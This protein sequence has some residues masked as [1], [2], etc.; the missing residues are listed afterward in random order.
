M[1]SRNRSDAWQP[2]AASGPPPTG[3]NDR[4]VVLA[5]VHA[6]WQYPSLP[7]F[8]PDYNYPEL[9]GRVATA[10]ERNVTYE[11]FREMLRL[12]GWDGPHFGLPDWNPLSQLVTPGQHVLI[13]PNLVR[14]IHLAEGDFWAVVTHPSLIRVVLD[15]VALALGG[16]GQITVGD[17]PLQSTN[18]EAL[19]ARTKLREVCDDVASSWHIPVRLVDFRLWSVELDEHHRVRRGKKLDGDISGYQCI[20]LGRRSLLDRIAGHHRRFRVTDY[21]PDEMSRHHNESVNEYV[22]P[23]TVLDADVVINLPKLKTHHKVCLTAGLKNLVGI[24]GHKDWLPHHRAGSIWEG[25]DEY[26]SR[27]RL[28]RWHA[29]CEEAIDRRPGDQKNRLRRVLLRGFDFV[30]RWAYP[31]PH[32]EGSW[33]GNDTLWRTVLDLN[34]LLVYADRNGEMADTPQRRCFTI[35]DA[36]VAGEGEGPMAPTPR[37]CG[38]LAAGANPAAV[39]ATLA[40]LVGF[41]YRRIPLIR[42]AFAVRD[43]PLVNFAP[44]DVEVISSDPRFAALRPDHPSDLL[45]FKP[46]EGWV[47]HV[48]AHAV[49][50]PDN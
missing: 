31:D 2:C 11:T 30:G 49:A 50:A 22:I 45:N 4:R 1:T 17:A 10:G 14:H 39:D 13:K 42:E 34:R 24:N 25:G 44:E 48:E 21:D 23:Q 40:A 47:G 29:R 43:W 36:I 35:V 7:P 18:F 20:D 9:Q 3:V 27:S 5:S 16:E 41:D 33:H 6:P 46:P 37:T 28:K 38:L 12:L 26:A 15:Y 32:R 19:L 8:L